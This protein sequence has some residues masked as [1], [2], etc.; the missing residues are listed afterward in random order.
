MRSYHWLPAAWL[1]A[2]LLGYLAPVGAQTHAAQTS[3]AQG[4][5]QDD[6]KAKIIK[7]DINHA[8]EAQLD[9]IKGIGPA[10]S[11]R[12]LAAR[13]QRPFEHWQDLMARIK[14]LGAATATRWSQQGLTVAGQPF[15]PTTA[16]PAAPSSA[17]GSVKP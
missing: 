10:T 7:I 9:G 8:S 2:G 16:V 15:T 5:L 11:Q 14:G 1:W 17:T 12:I 13:A 6:V 3:Q 4:R